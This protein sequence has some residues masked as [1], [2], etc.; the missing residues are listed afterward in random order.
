MDSEIKTKR[1]NIKLLATIIFTLILA[2]T[3]WGVYDV[4]L[5]NYQKE[6]PG[7]NLFFQVSFIA[8]IISLFFLFCAYVKSSEPWLFLSYL[9]SFSFMLF[10]ILLITGGFGF[11]HIFST[12]SRLLKVES[13]FGVFGLMAIFAIV[14]SII[15]IKK[16]NLKR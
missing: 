5:S 14:Y 11:D 1:G 4:A 6:T 9:F 8:G 16:R 2:M 3:F 12:I 10:L 15:L 7:L 13:I